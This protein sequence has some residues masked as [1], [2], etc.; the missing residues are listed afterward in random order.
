MQFQ[1]IDIREIKENAIRLIRDEWAL[2]TA[3][4]QKKWNTMTVSWGGIGELWGKDVAMIFIRPQRYT[5]EFI[6]REDYFTMSFFE[7]EY[8][9]ALSLCGSKSGRDID[10]AKEAGLTPLFLG[11]AVA[12][13]EAKLVFICRKVAYQDLDQL[14]FL[15][16][17]SIHLVIPPRII[18]VCMLEQL[19]ACLLKN[20]NCHHAFPP[21]KIAIL[22]S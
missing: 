14:G 3:G 6:E 2:I 4:D 13:E 18:T 7:K 19:N 12:I 10:K 15:I 21:I 22:P 11:S 1:E 9:K 17:R 20:N 16:H 8:K 5:Y